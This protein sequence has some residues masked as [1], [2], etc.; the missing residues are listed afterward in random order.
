MKKAPKKTAGTEF[1]GPI[2]VLR[3]EIKRPDAEVY[4]RLKRLSIL[5]QKAVNYFW[6]AWL[7]EH[8]KA[9]SPAKIMAFMEAWKLWRD[10]QKKDRGNRRME[11][12]EWPCQMLD[13]ELRNKLRAETLKSFPQLGSRL[14][15]LALNIEVQRMNA[16]KSNKSGFHRWMRILTYQGEL[17]Q[18]CNPQPIPF[19]PANAGIIVDGDD[20]RLTVKTEVVGKRGKNNALATDT[21]TLVT[22]AKK[23]RSQ[24]AEL[25]RIT[26]GEY[27]FCGSR[28]VFK[29]GKWFAHICYRQSR[30]IEAVGGD[31]VAFVRFGLRH[32]IVVRC[33]G[34]HYYPGGYHGRHIEAKRRQLTGHMRS[35]RENY[36]HSAS[37]GRGH[38]RRRAYQKMQVVRRI[39]SDFVDS[40]NKMACAK[41]AQTCK[42]LGVA[43]VQYLPPKSEGTRFVCTAGVYPGQQAFTGWQF[44]HFKNQLE[45]R[46]KREGVAFSGGQ[47]SAEDEGRKRVA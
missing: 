12:P 4:D 5:M 30:P 18:S 42:Q 3:F 45:E 26:R 20:Y 29:D 14:V 2:R 22:R 23:A 28:L 43:R 34:R 9:G 37:E 7:R 24:A 36:H 25:K 6:L 16:C 31:L 33:D 27:K 11:K 19:D 40:C 17:P 44:Y 10:T 15:D 47:D 8:L 21:F 13:N 39:W 32:P 41:I 1:T 38:G 46:L 35:R